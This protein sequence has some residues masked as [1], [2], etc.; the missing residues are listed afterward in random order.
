MHEHEAGT[1]ADAAACDAAESTLLSVV[2]CVDHPLHAVT[3][4]ELMV[5][6]ANIAPKAWRHE[7]AMRLLAR[8]DEA[9]NL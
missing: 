1:S 4:G 9:R 2:D 8:L 7:V 6:P 5:R 3:L